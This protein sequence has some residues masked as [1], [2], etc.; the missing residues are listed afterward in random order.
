MALSQTINRGLM[1]FLF[2]K[3][4]G[5]LG[6]LPTN[7]F[8]GLSSTTP[9]DSDGSN[10]TAP[11]STD[12]ARVSV[13]RTAGFG[14]PTDATPSEVDNEAIIQFALSTEQWDSGATWTH[15]TVH[16]AATGGTY[17]GSGALS[18]G[19]AITAA[20]QRIEIPAGDLNFTQT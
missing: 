5:A 20:G 8:I 16:D 13:A 14:D 9:D 17:W 12:Y 7:L 18:T 4:T 1:A 19:Q 15:V 3:T 2:D 6:T 10:I 11:T